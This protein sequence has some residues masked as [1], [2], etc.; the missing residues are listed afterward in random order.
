LGNVFFKQGQ[1]GRAIVNY[2]RAQRL[3]PHDSDV[4]ANLQYA[5]SL[6]NNSVVPLKQ[7][8]LL[9]VLKGIAK[10][11]NLDAWTLILSGIYFSV[12]M[13]FA[14]FMLSKKIALKKIAV[15]LSYCLTGCLN[16]EN[17]L[18]AT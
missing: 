12:L 6:C 8:W 16:G 5:L 15:F 14:G 10:H 4:R 2:E 3:L 7:F 18:L 9:S 1:I 11:L 17:Q 13:F